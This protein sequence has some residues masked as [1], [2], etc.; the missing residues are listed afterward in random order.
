VVL[1]SSLDGENKEIKNWPR[2]SPQLFGKR[3]LNVQGGKEEDKQASMTFG[4]L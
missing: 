3:K 4:A 2:E 1:F